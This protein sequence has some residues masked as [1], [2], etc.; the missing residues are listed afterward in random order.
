MGRFRYE[1]DAIFLCDSN[2][3]ALLALDSSTQRFVVLS[4]LPL[5]SPIIPLPDFPLR[6]PQ[7][8]LNGLPIRTQ[9]SIASFHVQFD[10]LHSTSSSTSFTLLPLDSLFLHS[11]FHSAVISFEQKT[12]LLSSFAL[13][14]LS[15][16]I[17]FQL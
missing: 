14:W 16:N 3:C 7:F 6:D 4:K 8:F 2:C 12:P 10:H 5:S 1:S 17:L 15:E 9:Q 11:P 13:S